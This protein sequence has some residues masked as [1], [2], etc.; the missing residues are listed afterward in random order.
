M[1]SSSG[2]KNDE[3]LVANDLKNKEIL[4]LVCWDFLDYEWSL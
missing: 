3:K 4:V 2:R 1:T